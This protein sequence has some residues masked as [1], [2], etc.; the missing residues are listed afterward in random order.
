MF[1]STAGAREA[2]ATRTQ[3]V[4]QTIAANPPLSRTITVN[5]TWNSIQG[6]LTSVNSVGPQEA[7]TPSTISAIGGQLHA[8]FNRGVVSLR[9]A[10]AD[11]SLMTTPL[12]MLPSTLPGTGGTPVK[13]EITERQ[14]FSDQQLRL[15]KGRFPVATPAPSTNT[16]TG[17]PVVVQPG[18][19]PIIVNPSTGKPIAGQ[20]GDGTPASQLRESAPKLPIIQVVMS[21][22]TAAAFGLHV[23]SK[24]EMIGPERASTGQA[25]K[26][27]ILVTGIVAPVDPSSTFWT[28][29]P[30]ILAPDLQGPVNGPYWAGAVMIWPGETQELEEY[31]S[32]ASMTLEWVFPL[33]VGS[34][35]GQQVQPLSQRARP[36]QH[37][38][39]DPHR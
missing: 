7:V 18:A 10:S 14:P 2:L 11:L 35:T 4:R 13:I 16:S 1:A 5:S 8:N 34:L 36:A 19:K 23:G 26:V 25:A 6:A 29:D 30:S 37:H 28:A 20:S 39:A 12:N 15:V 33:R 27:D 31:F 38:G 21:K 17:M 32:S 3:A 9:P 22:Q 24:F